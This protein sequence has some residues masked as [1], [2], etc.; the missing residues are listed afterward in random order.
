[1]F[2]KYFLGIS[3][4]LLLAVILFF[5]F[6]SQNIHASYSG[7]HTIPSELRG[8]WYQWN[9]YNH[10]L[11]HYRF[12]KYSVYQNGKLMLGKYKSKNNGLLYINKLGKKSKVYNFVGKA[13][14]GDGLNYWLSHKKVHG[15]R[16]MKLYVNQ[17][18]FSVFT[19]QKLHHDY[20]Y[21]YNGMD[22]NKKIG[23]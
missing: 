15:R 8:N 18:Y 23:L 2:K 12:N 22:Y 7:H 11:D 9:K 6:N 17:G 21:Q 20:S 13:D 19:R 1:M 14:F 3:F 10:K 5:N 16:V 4:A